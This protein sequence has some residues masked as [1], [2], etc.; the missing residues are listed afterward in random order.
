MTDNILH[1]T[2]GIERMIIH[3]SSDVSYLFKKT[4]N[5]LHR[6]SPET[7]QFQD[8]QYLYLDRHG[9]LRHHSFKLLHIAEILTLMG[10]SWPSGIQLCVFIPLCALPKVK[11]LVRTDQ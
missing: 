7:F 3:P 9:N 11:S 8:A 4:E 6:D 5:S 10:F 2:G 1:L